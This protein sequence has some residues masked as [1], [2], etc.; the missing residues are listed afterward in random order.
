MGQDILNNRITEQMEQ[1]MERYPKHAHN[2]PAAEKV[3]K[4]WTRKD[5]DVRKREKLATPEKERKRK[6]ESRHRDESPHEKSM[7]REKK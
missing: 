5:R 3:S 4:R 1:M 6:H 7:S 2:R